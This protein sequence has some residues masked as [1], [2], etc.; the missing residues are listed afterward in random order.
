MRYRVIM[1]FSGS[2]KTY[3]IGE[4]IPI[5][6]AKA[7]KNLKSL[8]AARYLEPIKEGDINGTTNTKA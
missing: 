4:I 5:Y 3:T 6:K 2:K 7:F 8:V 1:P